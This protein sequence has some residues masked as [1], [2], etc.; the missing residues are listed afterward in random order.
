MDD[1]NR[2]RETTVPAPSGW[3]VLIGLILYELAYGAFF[4]SYMMGH[5][6]NDPLAI[7]GM[8]LSVVLIPFVLPGFFLVNPN[9]SRVLV[10]FGSLDDE[11]C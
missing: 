1:T 11:S 10:L 8:I 5:G 2:F 3:P 9:M 7:A 4:V 6:Q